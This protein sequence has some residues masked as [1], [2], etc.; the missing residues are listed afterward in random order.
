MGDTHSLSLMAAFHGT[1]QRCGLVIPQQ[2]GIGGVWRRG[3]D[4]PGSPV[5][6]LSPVPLCKKGLTQGSS[7]GWGGVP[8]VEGNLR[9]MGGFSEGLPHLPGAQA[10]RRA[11]GTMGAP[12]KNTP[13]HPLYT[14]SWLLSPPRGPESHHWHSDL[15]GLTF[16]AYVIHREP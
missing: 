8:T 5:T 11:P 6:A 14:P 3:P 4:T 2:K 7:V 10:Q 16:V 1:P 9:Q 12:R 13:H 15:E